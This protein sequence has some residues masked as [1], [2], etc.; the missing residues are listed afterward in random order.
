MTLESVDERW[1]K[2]EG[3]VR[4]IIGATI[5]DTAFSQIKA[6]TSAKDTWSTLKKMHKERTRSLMA[7]MM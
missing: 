4:Q 7:D 5:P 2:E 1:R 6:C 3:M